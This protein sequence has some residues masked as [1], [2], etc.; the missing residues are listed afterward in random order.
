MARALPRSRAPFQRRA[1]SGNM[2]WAGFDTAA[3][4]VVPAATKTIVGSFTLSTAFEETVMRTR[5]I[6]VWRSDQTVAAEQV[7]GAFGAIVVSEDAFA[8]GAAS[9]PGPISDI[10]NDGWFMWQP[11]VFNFRV[12]DN[13]AGTVWQFDSKAKRI[14]RPGSRIAI[15]VENG[16]ATQGANFQ[17]VI[18]LLGK[19]RS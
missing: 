12:A 17:A 14:V 8:A 19:F 13:A 3:L 10:D 2:T 15:M 9:I 11:L 16:N 7:T 5:G 18:R 4:V 6:L 1:Q